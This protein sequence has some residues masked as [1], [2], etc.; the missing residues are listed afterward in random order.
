MLKIE[1]LAI[2]YNGNT[3]IKDLSFEFSDKNSYAIMG[4][5]GIGKTSLIKC[6]AGLQKPSDGKIISEYKNP[7]FVFQEPRLFP[8]LNAAEN[9]LTVC[10]DRSRAIKILK[11]LIP[12]NGVESKYPHELSGGMQ[13]RVAI[14]R[15]LAYDSDIIFLD[16]PFKGLDT[17]TEDHVRSYL[18]EQIK[19]KTAILVTHDLS[20]AKF[21]DHLLKLVNIQNEDRSLSTML[22]AEESGK[23]VNE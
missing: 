22:V 21:C 16:E 23:P 3:V 11:S 7:S 19:G 15:A 13:Q 17:E 20:D 12:E 14:A 10:S 1:N 6:M 18:F 4:T 8:W 9:I 5:S 2:T